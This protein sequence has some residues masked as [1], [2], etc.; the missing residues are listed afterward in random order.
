MDDYVK[1]IT[2][3]QPWA[4]LV[5]YGYKEFE[6]RSWK[7]SYTG[8]ILI[9]SARKWDESQ[10]MFY[11]KHA[12]SVL[13]D[14]MLSRG[15]ILAAANLV[16]CFPVEEVIDSTSSQEL[17]FGDFSK[18]RYAWKLENVVPLDFPVRWKGMQGLWQVE[19]DRFEEYFETIEK[20]G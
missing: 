2:I 10:K 17:L 16:G 8:P 20:D 7:T 9:H 19:S 6:T 14:V 13:G 11:K 1:V 3:W 5:A 18:G 12:M 4:S 15:K